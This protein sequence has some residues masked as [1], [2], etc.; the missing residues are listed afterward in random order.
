MDADLTL[1]DTPA[2]N[3]APIDARHTTQAQN[4]QFVA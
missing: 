2:H 3:R 1:R 4:T